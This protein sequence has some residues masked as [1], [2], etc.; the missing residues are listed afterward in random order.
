VR[1]GPISNTD[2]VNAGTGRLKMKT[3]TLD[4]ETKAPKHKTNAPGAKTNAPEGET[5]TLKTFKSG[6]FLYY[7]ISKPYISMLKQSLLLLKSAISIFI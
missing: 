6:L 2:A 5:N 4:D 3:K 1:D 7:Y